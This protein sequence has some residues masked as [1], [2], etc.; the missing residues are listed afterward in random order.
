MEI[1][2]IRDLSDVTLINKLKKELVL[3]TDG[4]IIK[5]Y[6]PNYEDIPGNL[7]NTL[8]TGRY[9]FGSYYILFENNE[10]VCSSGWHRYEYDHSIALVMTRSYVNP[11]FRAHYYMGKYLLPKMVAEASNYEKIWITVNEYNK[12]IYNRFFRKNTKKRSELFG[13]WPEIYDNFVALDKQ[14][15]YNTEQ[16]VIQYVKN[17]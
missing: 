2:T 12:A 3:I 7:F 6:H 17:N 13:N 1:Y 10:F 16:Y 8:K 5:N 11:K 4:N 14:L 9:E 15:I